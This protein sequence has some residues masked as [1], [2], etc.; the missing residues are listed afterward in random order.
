MANAIPLLEGTP[1]SGGYAVRP[2]YGPTLIDAINRESAVAALATV[3]Q[4]NTSV[5][6]YLVYKGRPTAAFVAEGAPK[7]AT[8]AEFAEAAINMKKIATTV[9]YTE[10]LLA[11]AAVDPT[12]LV[13][14]DVT[15]A[16]ADLVDAHALGMTAGAAITG[17]FDSEL[18]STSQTVELGTSGDA[19]AVA[20]ST[21]MGL[22]E[23]NGY[24]PSG[25][26]LSND[27]R[28]AMRAARGAGD[29][30]AQ[31]LYTPGFALEPTSM[32]GLPIT[33]STNLT[34]FS[35]AAASGNV[36]GLVGDFSNAILGI[37]KDIEMRA[38]AEATIDVGGTLHHL[39]QQN[40]TA[41]L[42]EARMGFLAHDLNRSFC[43]II[44]AA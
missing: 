38:T 5:E 17:N 21:A 9:M 39:F 24:K 22:V 28:V 2:Q 6:K 1:G 40:K 37:R 29:F 35:T 30:A 44:N 20:I 13:N 36:V 10:E 31:P 23:A 14:D 43:A 16:F 25:I 41:V 7:I 32:Y 3:R 4:V 42:W 11:D 15:R 12:T 26:I 34:K 19:L 18:T 33:Y 27:G 8:G